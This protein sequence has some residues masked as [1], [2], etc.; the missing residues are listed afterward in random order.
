MIWLKFLKWVRLVPNWVWMALAIIGSV[1]F[2]G[3]LRYNAGQ[4]DGEAKLSAYKQE[5]Q[6][7]VAKQ[8][9]QNAAKE[10]Q[11]RAVFA[12]IASQYAKD[13]ENA[14]AKSDSVIAGLRNGNIKLRKQ[15]RGCATPQAADGSSG[16]DENARLREE[17]AGRIIGNAAEADGWIKALQDVITQLQKQ[18]E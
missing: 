10:A 18:Q 5:V 15:W 14:K 3:H 13:I 9:A 8:I 7:A 1:M 16:I 11:D 12:Q 2:Y 17:S 6:K 4:A